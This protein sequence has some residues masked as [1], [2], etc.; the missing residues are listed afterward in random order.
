MILLTIVLMA[1][2]SAGSS[3][4]INCWKLSVYLKAVWCSCLYNPT[5]KAIVLYDPQNV[6]DKKPK[7]LLLLKK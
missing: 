3:R 5:Y 2:R 6:P 1:R 4:W 7:H